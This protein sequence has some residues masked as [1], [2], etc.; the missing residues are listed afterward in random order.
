MGLNNQVDILAH[1]IYIGILTNRSVCLRGFLSN[2]D[3]ADMINA[4]WIFDVTYMNK[5]I[6]PLQNEMLSSSES[7]LVTQTSNV[8]VTTAR[9]S[10]YE[11]TT[12]LVLT[13]EGASGHRRC[14]GQKYN[15]MIRQKEPDYKGILPFMQRDDITNIDSIALTSGLPLLRH[16]FSS[17]IDNKWIHK[18]HLLIRFNPVFY[19]V[20][21]VLKENNGIR[22]YTNFTAVHFRL[23]DDALGQYH[24]F[25][26]WEYEELPYV[27]QLNLKFNWTREE[28]DVYV[29]SKFLQLVVSKVNASDTLYFS[30]GLGKVKNRLN[31][32]CEL[33]D[34]YFAKVAHN[35]LLNNRVHTEVPIKGRE[36]SAI[37]DYIIASEANY[38]IGI[39][40]ST[41]S[42]NTA[43]LIN[44]KSRGNSMRKK[45]NVK[46]KNNFDNNFDIESVDASEEFSSMFD[47][48]NMEL[49]IDVP[50]T[51][52]AL[53][54]LLT[55]PNL[56]NGSTFIKLYR[57]N[58][59]NLKPFANIIP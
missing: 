42:N 9:G 52:D 24:Q 20:S 19:D 28:H 29:G 46:L 4:G 56:V 8:F 12:C 43:R 49:P 53:N 16:G 6:A 44:H 11:Q 37:I 13:G 50:V 59:P 23:E 41:F 1:S 45:D 22:S 40:A 38:F 33:L 17:S 27:K 36:S 7:A 2:F 5:L 10:D 14:P 34:G 25:N 57:E 51:F 54:T 15:V 39:S 58:N 47:V 55:V 35:N 21:Q 3:S 30:S 26:W 32:V 48:R 31:F 18:I